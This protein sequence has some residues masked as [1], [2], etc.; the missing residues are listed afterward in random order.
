MDPK[1]VFQNKSVSFNDFIWQI[2]VIKISDRDVVRNFSLTASDIPFQSNTNRPHAHIQS[3]HK[4]FVF[5][6]LPRNLSL[7][8]FA[9]KPMP[10]DSLHQC[11]DKLS[12]VFIIYNSS[13]TP[14][15]TSTTTNT[16]LLT[17][18]QRI[19]LWKQPTNSQMCDCECLCMLIKH[20][21]LAEVSH[22]HLTKLHYIG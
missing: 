20:N 12:L 18:E 15:A 7:H 19:K 6:H 4:F 3:T 2:S 10:N 11:V 17:S 16:P 14:T 13:S 21:K 5:A 8:P 1:S 9:I 22:Q